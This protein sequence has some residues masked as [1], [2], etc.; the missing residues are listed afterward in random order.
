MDQ[1]KL[2]IYIDEPNKYTIYFDKHDDSSILNKKT[3][4]DV[5]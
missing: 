3:Q 2:T 5:P 1:K 4:D